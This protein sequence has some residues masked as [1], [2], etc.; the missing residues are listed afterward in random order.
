MTPRKQAILFRKKKNIKNPYFALL[1]C[2]YNNGI[3]DAELSWL[4]STK[5]RRN[6]S[7]NQVNLRAIIQ[8]SNNSIFEKSLRKN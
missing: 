7:E 3:F 6:I 8:F 4:C 2:S 5:N 1:F